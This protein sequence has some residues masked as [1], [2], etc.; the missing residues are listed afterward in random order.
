M[1]RVSNVKSIAVVIPYFG[2]FRNDFDF[3]LISAKNNP[4]IDFLIF[5]DNQIENVSSN[6][7]VFRFTFEEMVDE[8][9]KVFDF[10]ICI[11][12][13]YKFCDYKGSYGE[14]FSRYLQGYDF[15]GYCDVDLIFGNIRKFITNDL[16]EHYDRIFGLGHFSLYR[17]NPEINSVFK[18]VVE[19]SYRQVFTFP[20]GCAFD[21]YWGTSRYWDKYLRDKFYQEC[22]YDDIDCM[23][24]L[25]KSHQK[26]I[27]DRYKKNIIFAYDSG[28]LYKIFEEKGEICKEETLY[29]HFQKRRMEIGT[30]ISDKFMM[31]PNRF[32]PYIENIDVNLLR[33]FNTSA[34]Y[35][36]QRIKL[37]YGSLKNK[38]RKIKASLNS[39]IYG[40]P[41][42]PKDGSL[43]Y[44][45]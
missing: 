19:P 22:L 30:I 16:L 41:K 43:Y 15:W 42:L 2:E 12:S 11:P 40:V 44:K 18:K 29:V 1:V 5:T 45:D 25:F 6:I 10:K 36:I 39:G 33:T 8:F 26:S 17:N 23:S 20:E 7:K 37:R 27:A 34:N 21:E 4:S 13:P 31:V 3:W 28:V 32:I 14:V 24:F 9:Q 35:C 38:L